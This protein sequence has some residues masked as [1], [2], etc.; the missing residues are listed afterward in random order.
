MTKRFR[1][2]KNQQ[3]LYRALETIAIGVLTMADSNSCVQ[4]MTEEEVKLVI[5]KF[6]DKVTKFNLRD[7]SQD[8]YNFDGYAQNLIL[9]MSEIIE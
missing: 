1:L 3:T 9:K 6:E 8:A 4:E 2:N 7:L 5:A